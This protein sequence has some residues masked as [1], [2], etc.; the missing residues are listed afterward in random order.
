MNKK[1][2]KIN[3]MGTEKELNEQQIRMLVQKTGFDK[4]KVVGCHVKFIE[5][6]EDSRIDYKTFEKICGELLP[7]NGNPTEFFKLILKG[8]VF[9]LSN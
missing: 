7:N 4:D 6:A 2:S 9:A 3:K 8:K 1:D 5:N